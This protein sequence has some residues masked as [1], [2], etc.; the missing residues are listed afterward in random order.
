MAR[1]ALGR[2]AVLRAQLK[3]QLKAKEEARKKSVKVSRTRAEKRLEECPGVNGPSRSGKR[4]RKLESYWPEQEGAANAAADN[5]AMKEEDVTGEHGATAG[6][7]GGLNAT[8]SFSPRDSQNF[9]AG[10]FNIT[11]SV[12][13]QLQSFALQLSPT[14]RLVKC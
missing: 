1:Q 6:L 2:E 12:I 5:P 11:L 13:L 8:F 14:P 9:F 10:E 7:V 3:S 4:I